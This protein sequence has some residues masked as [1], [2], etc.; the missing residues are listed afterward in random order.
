MTSYGQWVAQRS[1]LHGALDNATVRL[2]NLRNTKAF[3]D[4]A[5]RLIDEAE[6]EVRRCQQNIAQH[7]ARQPGVT[8]REFL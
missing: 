8:G 5:E 4:N 1:L 3:I 7:N 2:N 6:I